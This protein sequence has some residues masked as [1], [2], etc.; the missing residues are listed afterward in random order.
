[1]LAKLKVVKV[2]A[3]VILGRPNFSDGDPNYIETSK[4]K[5][6]EVKKEINEIIKIGKDFKILT[7]NDI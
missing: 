1:M 6:E 2:L 3:C 7:D 4:D 5:V